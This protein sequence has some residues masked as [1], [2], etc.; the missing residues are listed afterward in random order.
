MPPA[1]STLWKD[2]GACGT[3]PVSAVGSPVVYPNPATSSTV[4]LQLPVSNANNVTVQ[5]YTL[6]FREVKTINV[7]QVIGNSL[8]ISLVDKTGTQLA[9]GLYYFVIRVNGQR[10]TTKVLVLR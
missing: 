8:T 3:T 5:I 2:L 9:D 10:W 6:A 1:V 7:A 4:N